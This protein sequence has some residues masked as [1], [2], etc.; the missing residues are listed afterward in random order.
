MLILN[1]AITTT[2]I[3]TKNKSMQNFSDGTNTEK[4]A[5]LRH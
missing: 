2:L 5:A 4:V 1:M 3:A